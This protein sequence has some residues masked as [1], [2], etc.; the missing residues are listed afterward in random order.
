MRSDQGK[1]AVAVIFIVLGSLFL[2]DNLDLIRFDFK[3]YIFSWQS[4]MIFVGLMIMLK[5]ENKNGI[6][7][8]AIGGFFLITKIFS[9][10]YFDALDLWPLVFVIVGVFLIR[11]QNEAVSVIKGDDDFLN[12]VAIF[13]GNQIRVESTGFHGGTLT[14]IFG[15]SSIDLRKCSLAS[16][17]HE[18]R[19]FTLFGGSKIIVP[20]DMAVRL[21]VNPVL[22]E[23][24][25]KREVI[26]PDHGDKVLIITGT[27]VFGECVLIN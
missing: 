21:S 24:A 27:V 22:A 15:G 14:A 26:N 7:L 18:L 4:I 20:E 25:D 23:M 9:S 1:T 2:L 8:V 13:G 12:E 19:V 5:G 10:F 17:Q 6:I 16:G 3:R 11:R